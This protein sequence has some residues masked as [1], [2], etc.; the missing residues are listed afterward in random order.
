MIFKNIQVI[1]R[2]VKKPSQFITFSGPLVRTFCFILQ[3]QFLSCGN[4]LVVSSNITY[5][6]SDY[7]HQVSATKLSCNNWN[8]TFNMQIPFALR[9]THLIHFLVGCLLQG[10]QVYFLVK[11]AFDLQSMKSMKLQTCAGQKPKL[12]V[13]NGGSCQAAGGKEMTTLPPVSKELCRLL[14]CLF[15]R[16]PCYSRAKSCW[17][18]SSLAFQ[19]PWCLGQNLSWASQII[20]TACRKYDAIC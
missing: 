15:T 14:G 16:S 6:P 8:L 17:L 13:Q 1:G 9:Y 7:F 12:L 3:E 18:L 2:N 19:H 4:F 5:Q 11:T 10:R 20:D